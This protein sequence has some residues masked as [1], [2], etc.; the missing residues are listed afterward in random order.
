MFEN[1]SS[2]NE[3][4]SYLS[5]SSSALVTLAK[6][7]EANDSLV[8]MKLTGNPTGYAATKD[9]ANA[10]SKNTKMKKFVYRSNDIDQEGA[11][12]LANMLTKN[13][14]LTTLS[15]RHNPRTTFTNP[16]VLTA[17]EVLA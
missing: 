3:T 12:A 11:I 6:V 7:I 10:L 8:Y 15:L 2:S 13:V 14:T 5:L 9:I 16:K 4:N 17:F 1:P